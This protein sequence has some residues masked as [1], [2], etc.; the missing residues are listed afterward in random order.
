[1][2][3]EHLHILKQGVVQW[4]AWR[5][6]NPKIRP[7]LSDAIL[8]Q[9][10]LRGIN[11]SGCN[12]RGIKVT[13][14]NLSA[15]DS[16]YADMNNELKDG[17]FVSDNNLFRDIINLIAKKSNEISDLSNAD[18]T[19]ALFKKC[20]IR[21][22]NFNA[23]I[24]IDT[25]ADEVHFMGSSFTNTNLSNASLHACEL[26]ACDF[27]Q[28]T[29]DRVSI[30]SS[31]LD[32]A[33]FY[34]TDLICADLTLSDLHNTEFNSC[35]LIEVNLRS[36]RLIDTIFEK[37]FISRCE[38]YGM[39]AWDI[40]L[41]DTIQ[42]NLKITH[43]DDTSVTL[44]DLELAPFMY[45][46][47]SNAKVRKVIDTVTSKVVL[48]LGRFTTERKQVLDLIR[49]ELKHL[50][51]TPIIFDFE[52]PLSKDLTGTVETLARLSRFI[53]ADLT[54]PSSIPHELAT[55]VPFLRTTPVVP[56]R[57]HGTGG[58]TMF[59]DLMKAYPWVMPIY[60]YTTEETLITDLISIISPANEMVDRLRQG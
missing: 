48:I 30:T 16:F 46:L 10:D 21:F 52:K 60:E 19:G 35:K 1:M 31:E 28:T 7:D 32:G 42:E 56:I 37:C 36:S 9:V 47:L 57:L 33:R 5:N 3:E 27:F 20:D 4:N 24:L 40:K 25:F 23:A 8:D 59:T 18:L 12:L 34:Q 2:N 39:A 44:D 29:L 49:N 50:N 43:Q 41:N 38:L 13:Y 26:E 17:D 45:M 51:L 22:V 53:I 55:I 58:Y 54:D 11:L 15:K 6:A 14:S